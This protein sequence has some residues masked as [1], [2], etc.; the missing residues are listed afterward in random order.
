MIFV[1]GVHGAGKSRFCGE[2]ERRLGVDTFTASALIAER[3]RVGFSND[4]PVPDIEDNQQHLLM[5]VR[6]VSS[7]N[8]EFILDGHF[9]LL[10]AEGQVTRIPIATFV[11]LGPA[12]IVL[13][14]EDPSLIADRRRL[15]DGIVH[16]VASIRRFQDAKAVYAAEVAESLGVPFRVIVGTD[17]WSDGLDFVRDCLER[18]TDGR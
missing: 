14:T 7:T 10:D 1:G 9:C 12:A 5:A 4:K 2:V 17:D 13:L 8:P 16:D 3:T 15:R 18:R 11:A 6:G